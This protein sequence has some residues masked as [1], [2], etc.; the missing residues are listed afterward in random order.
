VVCWTMRIAPSMHP[1]VVGRLGLTRLVLLGMVVCASTCVAKEWDGF[2]GGACGVSPW[3]NAPVV[4]NGTNGAGVLWKTPLRMAGSSSP[5]WWENRIFLTESDDAER[6]MLAF[7]A[8]TGKLLWRGVV[9]DGGK[10]E[11]LPTASD[12]GL[13]YPTPTCESNGVYALFGTG[14]LAAFTHDGRLKWQLFIRRPVIGYGFSSSPCV[15]QGMIFVQFDDH[16]TG[17]I[18]AVDAVTGKIKWQRQRSRGASW[19]TPIIIPGVHNQPLVVVSGNGSVTAYDFDGRVVWDEDGPTG[20]IAPSPS[21]WSNRLYVVNVNSRLMCYDVSGPAVKQWDLRDDLS[22]VPS[23]VVVNGLLFMASSQGFLSCV[24]AVTGQRLW[25]QDNPGCYASLTASGDRIF[26]LGRDGVMYI[27]AAERTYRVISVCELGD[28][29]DATPAF[30]DGRLCIR[31]R[32]NLWCL[33]TP[34][35][36]T[37]L[38]GAH[39]QQPRITFA[40]ASDGT[41]E[42]TAVVDLIGGCCFPLTSHDIHALLAVPADMSII[43]GPTPASYPALTAPVSGTAQVAA[44][45]TWKLR[46]EHAQAECPLTVTVTSPDSGHVEATSVM[47]L[48][49]ACHINGPHLPAVLPVGESLPISVEADCVDESHYV[50]SVRFWYSTSAPR[51]A[52][53]LP[54]DP[55]LAAHGFLGFQV[56]NRRIWIHG[57]SID[58][59]RKYNPTTWYG[60]IPAQTNGPLYGVAVVQDDV[61]GAS[62]G[63]LV[64]SGV[65]PPG[66]STEKGGAHHAW[67]VLAGGLLL[68]VAGLALLIRKHPRSGRMMIAAGLC[69]GVI[70]LALQQTSPEHSA[71]HPDVQ[72]GV[73][74]TNGSSV[75]YL[76]LD[77]SEESRKIA[78]A[79]NVLR[80]QDPHRLHELTFLAGVTPDDIMNAQRRRLHLK[81]LPAIVFDDQD[82]AVND[83]QAI[84]AKA[85]ACMSK[86]SPLLSMELRGGVIAGRTLSLG[87]IMCNH[88]SRPEASG[89]LSVFAFENHV[90]VGAWRCDHIVRRQLIADRSYHIPS[91]KCQPPSMMT[92]DLPNGVDATQV[93]A[94]TLIFDDQ[95]RL[96]DSICT[97]RPCSRTGICD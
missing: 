8:D 64:I 27:I 93:G 35:G 56:D 78:E 91:K 19:T 13:A 70:G 69:L 45:F 7:D 38:F 5:V 12:A 57:H 32:N 59:A 43:S 47:G 72:P 6:A 83:A 10:K 31:G 67:V 65:I 90:A 33:G 49:S 37:T 97:E 94:L 40:T 18:I 53:P 55:D 68:A 39:L 17:S 60:A 51:N 61:G 50:Q 88:T 87:L 46:R 42:V 52:T 86:D 63:P 34:A 84:E 24:D 15:V 25:T 9:P 80:K 95:N 76:F 48:K 54:I 96:I 1:G 75:V 29:S 77:A 14:D 62:C 30:A 3:T 26:A 81:S 92:W 89:H 73:C 21:W 22:D 85:S 41:I 23:P 79:V 44:R 36:Q 66:S 2:R 74:P 82:V 4:W 28:G 20:E 71:S 58:L 11:P 16:A